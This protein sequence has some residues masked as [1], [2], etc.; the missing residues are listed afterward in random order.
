MEI[1]GLM[2][3]HFSREAL[4]GVY[5]SVDVENGITV[6]SV[7]VWFEA[8]QREALYE[9]AKLAAFGP[10]SMIEEPIAAAKAYSL[11]YDSMP[12]DTIV[13]LKFE[14]HNCEACLLR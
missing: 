4:S 12:G 1:A 13:V 3:K 9:A 5:A 10:V 7:P 6:L 8:R 14:D 2:L 11:D